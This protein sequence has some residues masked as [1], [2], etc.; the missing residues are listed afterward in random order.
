VSVGLWYEEFSQ[1]ERAARRSRGVSRQPAR[2]PESPP[3]TTG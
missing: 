3:I 1:H 2:S